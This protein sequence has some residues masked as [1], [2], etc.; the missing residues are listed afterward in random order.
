MTEQ[1][2]K[3]RK[4]AHEILG[5]LAASAGITLVLQQFLQICGTAAAERIL[6][7]HD[8]TLTPSQWEQLDGWILRISLLLAAGFFAVLFLALLGER[9][10]YIRTITQGIEILR[11]GDFSHVLPL[12]GSN[13]LTRLA[14]AVNYLCA[15]QQQVQAKERALQQEKEQL[16][17]S[18]SHDIRT[19]LTSILAYGEYLSSVGDCPEEKR[20]EYLALIRSKAEQIRELTDVLLSGGARNPEHFSDARLLM[21]QLAEAFAEALE[22]SFAVAVDLDACPGFA[23]TFDVSELRRI[24]DN[25]VSN[26]KKYADPAAPVTLS[27]RLEETGLTIRQT[28]AAARRAPDA[29]SYGMGLKSIRRIAHSY[30]GTVA[31]QQIQRD[32]AITVV[33]AKF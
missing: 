12:E 24:F 10:A 5:L 27:V 29:Q 2:K 25:L 16:I 23:G 6:F 20:R 28:N 22:D 18:L 17:R 19:P 21:L 33:L 32:F 31:V 13:E 26:V 3:P 1:T 30:D 4:L 15:T 14:E 11:S 8:A 7:S 9:L